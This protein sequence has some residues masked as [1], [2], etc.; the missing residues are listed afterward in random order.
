VDEVE[1]VD[2]GDV[3]A[4]AA[5]HDVLRPIPGDEAISSGTAPEA[6][7]PRPPAEEVVSGEAEDPVVP[8][9]SIQPVGV[10]RAADRVP[11]LRSQNSL[12]RRGADGDGEQGR[13]DSSNPS[14]AFS[15]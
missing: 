14:A 11:A 10:W 15:R 1:A 12:C 9:P 5:D 2:D 7:R 13:A 8:A 6:I 3:P 4:R